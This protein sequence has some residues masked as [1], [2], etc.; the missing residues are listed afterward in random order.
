ML[1]FSA[2]EVFSMGLLSNP[3]GKPKPKHKLFIEQRVLILQTMFLEEW[4]SLGG[5][6]THLFSLTLLFFYNLPV[7]QLQCKKLPFIALSVN[8][9]ALTV[10][11]V[12]NCSEHDP[13]VFAGIKLCG[14][15]TQKVP[16]ALSPDSCLCL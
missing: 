8:G 12:L 9:D 3:L 16:S 13:S 15:L 4:S 14:I 10:V 11:A 6:D 5:K 2:S 7:C 1:H